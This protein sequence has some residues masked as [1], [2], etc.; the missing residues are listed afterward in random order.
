MGWLGAEAEA[1]VVK[2]MHSCIYIEHLGL[3]QVGAVEVQTFS[4]I[5]L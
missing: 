5:C 2:S 3:G 4:V 1:G